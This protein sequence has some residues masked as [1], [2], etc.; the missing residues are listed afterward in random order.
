MI[1][2]PRAP[3]W[4]EQRRSSAAQNL[5]HMHGGSALYSVVRSQYSAF[6]RNCYPSGFRDFQVGEKIAHRR[7]IWNLD[8]HTLCLL[9]S[10]KTLAQS[11]E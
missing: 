7:P 10:G 6:H 5:Q 1:L 2:C 4:A 11:P 9:V 8:L 3:F